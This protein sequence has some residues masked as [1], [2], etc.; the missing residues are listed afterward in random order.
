MEDAVLAAGAGIEAVALSN[1]GGRQLD[2]APAPLELLGPVADAVGDQVELICDGGIRRGSDIVKARRSRRQ[3]VHGRPGLPVRL[4]GGGRA[5]RRPPASAA[6]T[7]RSAGPWRS[8]DPAPSTS[9]GAGLV[10]WR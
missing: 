5:R 1:H 3:G 8:P 2:G 9:L 4:R 10:S 6:S 7:P